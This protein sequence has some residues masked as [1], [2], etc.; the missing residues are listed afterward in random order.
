MS[1]VKADLHMHLEETS[2][3]DD[4]KALLIMCE[5]QGLGAAAILS[6]NSIA[7]YQE[8]GAFDLLAKETNN[9]FSQYFSGKIIP[10][11]EMVSTM[12]DMPSESGKNYEG[13][14]SDIVLYDFDIEKMSK[15]LNEEELKKAWVDDFNVF[16]KKCADIGIE[17]PP[18]ENFVNDFHPLSFVTQWF[19]MCKQIPGYIDYLEEVFGLKLNTA[20]DLT[21]NH[22]SNPNGKLFFKQRLFP[23][24]STVLK[25][26]KEVG[27]KVCI[28]HPAYMSK[29]FDTVDYIE[30][31][32]D[33]SRSNP[34]FQPIT[35]VCGDYMLNTQKDSETIA[36]VAEEK[37]LK[38]VCGSDL[39]LVDQMYYVGPLTNGEKVYYTPTPGF[40]VAKSVEKGDGTIYIAEENLK[41]F[42]D[43]KDSFGKYNEKE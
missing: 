21:R 30:T 1:K 13:Y 25:I 24:V 23:D 17:V 8:G 42:G 37:G 43:V 28:A 32:T 27:A 5:A 33:F 7:I 3:I 2:T 40:A 41:E 4:L 14:R 10:S 9:D 38:L 18:I 39:R 11:V 31:L 20:S 22:I 26:A 34:E 29:D 19:E 15:Y 35:H 16:S 12:D 36:R 6:Y